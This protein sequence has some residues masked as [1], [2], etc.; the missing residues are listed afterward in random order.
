MK[1]LK[2]GIASREAYKKRT[3]AIAKG[4]SVPTQDEPKVW[5]ESSDALH[6]LVVEDPEILSGTPVIRGTRVP[7]YDIAA[8]VDAG[9]SKERILKSYPSLKDWQVELASVYAKA[10]P[11]PGRPK[12]TSPAGGHNRGSITKKRLRTSLLER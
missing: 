4:E 7:V 3:L 11:P 8:A 2:V 10:V 9:T 6:E 5:L 12:R 1:T